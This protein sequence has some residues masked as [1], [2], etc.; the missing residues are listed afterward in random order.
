LAIAAEHRGR[1]TGGWCCFAEFFVAAVETNHSFF[2]PL[3]LSLSRLFVAGVETN[4]SCVLPFFHHH[5]NQHFITFFFFFFP[6][7][8]PLL[9]AH[10]LKTVFAPGNRE[11]GE[12]SFFDNSKK[13][14]KNRN[15]VVERHQSC[16][17]CEERL[18]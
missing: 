12:F 7:F 16:G 3:C 9:L 6:F 10:F 5:D 17:G 18:D 11:K 13:K 15:F 2:L 1:K 14:A 8:L 4:H